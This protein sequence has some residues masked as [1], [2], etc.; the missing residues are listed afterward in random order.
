MSLVFIIDWRVVW[1]YLE[2]FFRHFGR[3]DSPVYFVLYDPTYM[4]I[5]CRSDLLSPG[6]FPYLCISSHSESDESFVKW[7]RV[8][9]G[10]VDRLIPEF[11]LFS[12]LVAHT[13][14]A[15]GPGPQFL[16]ARQ[17]GRL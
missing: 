13:K 14:G 10:N 12:H 2:H 11:V 8:S 3:D 6:D 15:L 17:V 4:L 1:A 7:R 16:P 5:K 9:F